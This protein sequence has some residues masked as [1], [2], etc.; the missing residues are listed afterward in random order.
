ME[1]NQ[2]CLHCKATVYIRKSSWTRSRVLLAMLATSVLSGSIG[3]VI[4]GSLNPTFVLM[5]TLTPLFTWLAISGG[6]KILCPVCKDPHA[7]F[8]PLDWPKAR[9]LARKYNGDNSNESLD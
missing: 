5:T 7:Q 1:P 9:Y 8:M 3:W 6:T 2:L 4:E